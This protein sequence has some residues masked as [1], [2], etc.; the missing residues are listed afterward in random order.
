M[1]RKDLGPKTYL[2]PQPVIIL[3]AYDE[4]GKVNCMNAAW[5]AI[6]DYKELSIC[7]SSDHKTVANILKMKDFTVSPGVKSQVVACD[8][9]GIES[10]NRVSDKFLKTGW[11]QHRALHVN[12]PIIEEL[13]LAIECRLIDYNEDTGIMRGAIINVSVD[14]RYLK[15]DGHI[16][17]DKLEIIS[18]D[19]DNNKYL[20][21]KDVVGSAFSDGLKIKRN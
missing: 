8:Y 4:E 10:G 16:D 9:V 13:P 11:H 20:L 2:Y 14:E 1:P 19:P 21:V 17:T 15:E 5:G 7:L 18:F 12:A 3:A 6:S